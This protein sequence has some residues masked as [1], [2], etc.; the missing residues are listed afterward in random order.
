MQ[1]IFKAGSFELVLSTSK[2]NLFPTYTF[3]V[4]TQV[5]QLETIPFELKSHQVD[6]DIG[7]KWLFLLVALSSNSCPLIS[8]VCSL[9]Y[10]VKKC[11]LSCFV[12]KNTR[13]SNNF[14]YFFR[15]KVYFFI[16]ILIY[17]FIMVSAST[18]SCLSHLLS[19]ILNSQEEHSVHM[20][21]SFL[22]FNKFIFNI[23]VIFTSIWL[24]DI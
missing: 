3:R 17:W 22:G 12:Q 21:F 7:E 1:F 23:I 18:T 6:F 5:M 19:E 9:N 16:Y 13:S 14:Y 11:E 2:I 4:W 20:F 24:K 8:L 15:F 10:L